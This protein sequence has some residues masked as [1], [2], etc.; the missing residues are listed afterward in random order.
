[1]EAKR[2]ELT[3]QR[4]KNTESEIKGGRESLGKKFERS[5]E[6]IEGEIEI[7]RGRVRDEAKRELKKRV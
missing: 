1:M 5:K 6:R 2:L 4:V 3:M 7:T